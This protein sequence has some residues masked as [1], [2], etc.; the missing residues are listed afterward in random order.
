MNKIY[1]LIILL[2]LFHISQ[3]QKVI[4]M[5]S[6]GGV[7]IIPCKVNGLNL[8][9]VFDTGAS[10][11]S[12]SLTE[13]LF[14]LKNDYLSSHD[15]IGREKY[16]DATGSI[17]E[18]VK[19]N[20]KE[21]EI[22]GIKIYNVEASI[23]KNQKAPLLLGQS[24]ISKLGQIQ[25]DLRNNTLTISN[26]AYNQREFVDNKHYLGEAFDGGT[27][28][29]LDESKNH[30]LIVYQDKIQITSKR[31]S[32]GTYFEAVNAIEDLGFGW[33]L[34]TS[35]ELEIL[36]SNKSVLKSKQLYTKNEF[37]ELVPLK[38]KQEQGS[39]W[40]SS[41]C[42]ESSAWIVD[43]ID[44]EKS[45]HDKEYMFGFRAIKSF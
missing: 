21:I 13:A 19:I 9:F 25:I 44:G 1:S 36:H 34:P 39:F 37:G 32:V 33:R 38:S 30:G 5:Q 31:A 35:R 20:L 14:M 22:E 16:K 8:K 18:G 4:K 15:I 43:F 27:I 7:S 3:A 41:T 11:V 17:S 26:S 6:E 42:S 23:V 29:Y 10:N 40:S 28:F 2:L 24:A 12:I 45:C